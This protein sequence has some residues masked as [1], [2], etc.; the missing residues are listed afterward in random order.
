MGVH[1]RHLPASEHLFHAI[2][3]MDDDI[4]LL[5]EF[6]ATI[7]IADAIRELSRTRQGGCRR[8][9]QIRLATRIR[10]IWGKQVEHCGGC[11][12]HSESG[13]ASQENDV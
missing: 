1:R 6:P 13:T 8:D 2:G 12:I 9:R 7:V 4:H 5:F 11:A 10:R 3:V